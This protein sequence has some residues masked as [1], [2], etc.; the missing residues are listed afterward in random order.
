[1]PISVLNDCLDFY[2]DR[3]N[4]KMRDDLRFFDQIGG[5]YLNF[6]RN[7]VAD[8]N[9]NDFFDSL[10]IDLNVFNRF[11]R[12]SAADLTKKM[13]LRVNLP[14]SKTGIFDELFKVVW[15][16]QNYKDD[17]K[18]DIAQ[19]LEDAY[20][21]AARVATDTPFPTLPLLPPEVPWQRLGWDRIE[22]APVA[23]NYVVFSDHHMMDFSADFS[24]P[25]F[26]LDHNLDLYLDVLDVYAD[27][28]SWVL[29][30]NGDVEECV[31]FEV[32]Q[33]DA[34]LREE[35][36]RK[37]KDY[38]VTQSSDDWSA[39]MTHRYSERESV[40]GQLLLSANFRPYYDKIRDRFVDADRYVRLT[41]NHDTYSDTTRERVLRD[42]IE[43]HLSTSSREVSVV[44]VSR[45]RRNDEITHLVMHGH[46]FDSVSIMS[47]SVPYALSLG[48]MFSENLSWL[49]EGP[50]RFWAHK[51]TRAWQSGAPI[52]NV[53]ARE[54]P[55]GADV[56]ISTA[57]VNF[58]GS[59]ARDAVRDAVK[60][61]PKG[62]LE[63]ALGHEIAWQYFENDDA[64]HA[65]TLEV[66][67]GDEWFK[68]RHL[69]E[70]K[71]CERYEN[72]YVSYA[73]FPLTSP[74]PKLV[75]GHTHEPRANA[76]DPTRN[77]QPQYLNSG[78]A[79]RFENLIWAVEMTQN[80]GD[81][82][83]SWSRID[84]RLRKTIWVDQPSSFQVPQMTPPFGMATRFTSEL[85]V[86][87]VVE[88]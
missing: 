22:D 28:P 79:G 2:S 62:V 9:F 29:M 31:I 11:L 64:Y 19:D 67:T 68:F 10:E 75:L 4:F 70:R 48:E 3:S 77:T 51:D 36:A 50:D 86:Q 26:F 1:M 39:F 37:K 34:N 55:S 21:L 27:D 63:S 87:S 18:D 32:S 84:G 20:D 56:D 35:L 30:E 41:G 14:A 17:V 81:R 13:A 40:L 57:L 43:G 82:I 76:A 60:A 59:G 61:D 69:D 83:V 49:Y 16:A 42:M 12:N 38:P 80:Q 6:V 52:E 44:D 72:R 23:P 85:V 33:G 54:T 15:E 24:L 73:G 71:L 7:G 45:V 66:L 25:N 78:S 65:L 58:F 47:G 53:L 74:P 5:S 8:R 46:Q 88:Y